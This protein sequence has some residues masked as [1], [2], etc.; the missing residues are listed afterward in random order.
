MLANREKECDDLRREND[1]FVMRML[2]EKASMVAELNKMNDIVDGL[3][4][5]LAASKRAE[6]D[7]KAAADDSQSGLVT[8]AGS[9]LLVRFVLILSVSARNTLTRM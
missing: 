4:A 7:G 3:K 5:Q 2:E 9:Q 8:D 6:Q 1:A